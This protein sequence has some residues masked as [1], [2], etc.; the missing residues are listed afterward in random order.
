MRYN[1]L[2]LLLLIQVFVFG[3]NSGT[4]SGKVIDNENNIVD[5][6][7]V[8]L[9][10]VNDSTSIVNGTVTDNTGSFT[11]TNVPFGNYFIKLQFVGFVKHQQIVLLNE[12]SKNQ[13]LG[14]IILK[15]DA[16][17]LNSVEV[18]A[19][20]K[21]IQKNEEGIVVNA[22]ENLTQIGGTAA[23]LMKNMPGVQVDMEGNFTMRG[24]TPLIM[25]NGRI[26]GLGGVD[27]VSNLDQI[28]ASTIERIELITNPSAKYDADAESGIINIVLKNNTNLG[29]NGAA[30]L[31]GGFGARYRINGSFL[32]NHNTNRWDLGVAYDNWFT[33]RTRTV[34]KQRTQYDSQ[35][36]YYLSQ[37]REDERTIQTQTA[38]FNVGYTPNKKNSFRLEGIWLFEGQ[39]NHETIVST[40]K[41][42]SHDFTSRNSRYSNEIR[43]FHTGELLFNYTRNFNQ[44]RVLTFDVSSAIEY[45]RENTDISTQN[46][47]EQNT[48]IGDPFLQ[49]THFFEDANLTNFAIHYEHPVKKKGIL[50]TGYK[51]TI[52]FINDNYLR[53]NQQNGSFIT[54]SAH[55]DIFKFNEQIHA[56]FLQ[57]TGWKGT[58]QEPIW[59]YQFGLRVEPVWNDGDN[60][61]SAYNFSN[62]YSQFFPS[63]SLIY[64]TEKRN[65]LKLAYSKR[66]NRPTIGQ[67]SP[68]IDITDSLNVW[69]GNSDIQPEISHAFGLT[70]NHVLNKASL[71][72]SLFYRHKSNSIFP[73]TTINSSGVSTTSPENFGNSS[74]YG[75]EVLLT[76]NPFSFWAINFD[77]SLYEQRIEPITVL[78]NDMERL[79]SG[80]VKFINNIDVWKNSRFQIIANYTSPVVIPQGTKKEVYFVDFGFQQ[81]I[82]NAQGRL[83]LT[84]T[85]IFNTQSSETTVSDVNFEYSHYRKVDTRAIMLIFAYTFRSKFK[86]KLLENKFKNE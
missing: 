60:V 19:F 25:I 14:T 79:L 30:A 5:F 48:E 23:E 43:R 7:N 59:K 38:R 34:N 63:A 21:L 33:T 64:Y 86:E 51:T 4:I 46:L 58:Q 18:A 17:A 53:A 3:Q 76:Y 72:S 31:G 26:S 45:N 15:T 8:Y 50:E 61:Y 11:L 32:I 70:Y 75:A 20:R 54:D 44:H 84:I 83:A 22:S 16:I 52:R 9:T 41:T 28:P 35:D 29:T 27:R 71:S 68:F 66:I 55:T 80:Y 49:K 56:L 65:S 78:Q 73:Y 12:A 42:S 2:I 69:S 37:P 67:Y 82:L 40:T 74:T 39:D 47:S 6:A 62:E 24:K 57:Y 13:N 36:S 10:S 85:D 77:A 1:Y 81:K